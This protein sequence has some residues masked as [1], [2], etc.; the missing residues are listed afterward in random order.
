LWWPGE[1]SKRR[2][3]RAGCL[4]ASQTPL[5]QVAL[6]LRGVL[7]AQILRQ[8]NSPPLFVAARHVSAA[9]RGCATIR[10]GDVFTDPLVVMSPSSSSW[11]SSC[12]LACSSGCA[13]VMVNVWMSE[14]RGGGR[15][16]A[17]AAQGMSISYRNAWHDDGQGARA[18]GS[19]G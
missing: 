2:G 11:S 13:S 10:D 3:P 16:C 9:L 5:A 12:S 14:V 4:A 6:Q 8:E 18:T 15:V 17:V 1:R 7:G 19:R